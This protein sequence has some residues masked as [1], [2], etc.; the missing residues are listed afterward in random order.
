[1]KK[2]EYIA[3]AAL[4]VI[5]VSI[6]A[7]VNWNYGKQTASITLYSKGEKI[8][9]TGYNFDGFTYTELYQPPPSTPTPPFNFGPPLPTNHTVLTAVFKA[10]S[11]YAPNPYHFPESE[12]ADPEVDVQL[13]SNGNTTFNFYDEFYGTIVSYNAAQ[14]TI[15]LATEGKVTV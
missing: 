4:V 1:M 13:N 3:I 14:Q 10:T 7:L 8:D 11:K 6:T 2:S 9:D 5:F 15:L 12:L